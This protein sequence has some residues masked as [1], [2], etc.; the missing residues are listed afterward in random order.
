MNLVYLILLF[1]DECVL[2]Y[3]YSYTTEYKI[4]MKLDTGRYTFLYYIC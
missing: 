4:E 2:Q 3:Y 1:I